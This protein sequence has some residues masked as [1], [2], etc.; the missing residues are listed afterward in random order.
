MVGA[1]MNSAQW[2][3]LSVPLLRF[4]AISKLQKGNALL[5]LQSNTFF[6]GTSL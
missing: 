4:V 2:M 5:G 1:W 6:L 3:I